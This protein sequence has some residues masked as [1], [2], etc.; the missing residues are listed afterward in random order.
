MT[1]FKMK[2]VKEVL[3]TD[4]I[5]EEIENFLYMCRISN[6][7]TAIW[8]DGIIILLTPSMNTEK[9]VERQFEGIRMYDK[10][11]FVK[12][13]KYTKTVKW[14][15]GIYELPLRN[16]MNIQRFRE[17]AKWVKSQPVWETVPE[18]AE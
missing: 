9:N 18:K 11:I 17:L 16:Y 12:Y 1:E 8:V 15:G 7:P 3:I 6:I 5:H 14:N 4:L 13:P 10:L 2:A